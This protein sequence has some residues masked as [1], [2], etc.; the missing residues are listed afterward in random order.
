MHQ[1][2]GP[3]RRR[4]EHRRGPEDRRPARWLGGLARF[5]Q[6]GLARSGGAGLARFRRGGLAT[7]CAAGLLLVLAGAVAAPAATSTLYVDK[8]NPSCSNSGPGNSAVPYCSI[9]KAATAAS[10][11]QTVLVA[12]G[13]YAETVTVGRSGTA[14]APIIFRAQGAVTVRGATYGFRI[15]SK[16]WIT[17]RG[18]TITDTVKEGILVSGSSNITLTGNRVTS[19]GTPASGQTAQGIELSG[20]N[21]ATVSANVTDHNSEAGIQLS[22]SSTRNVVA[23]NESFANARGYTRAAPGIDVRAP[24]NA[25]IGNRAHHNEDTGIQAYTGGSNTLIANNLTWG[26]GDH[27][28][29]DLN[30]PGQRIIGNT[31]YDNVTAGINVEGD[32][33]GATVANNVS[34]DNGIDSPRTKGNIR[35]D[36]TS[37][38]GTTVNDNLVF[39]SASA[40]M[41]TWGSTGYSSLTAFRAA[42]GQ[43]AR[44]IQAD[45][46]FV[47]AGAGDF[48]LGAGSP[49]VDSAN[50]GVSGQQATD[51]DGRPRT[52]DPGVANTGAGP[53]RYDDRGALER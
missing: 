19:A 41:Y 20:T 15:S 4:W 33:P 42:T 43:E 7:A 47:G 46:R 27:G 30:V 8:S 26:N 31:V 36:S 9:A 51:A 40:V 6:S 10:A 34:V 44:G 53:R 23:G 37:V 2:A 38:S 52:D 39:L 21:D 11:G 12:A 18:F 35:V 13:T 48:R 32:S 45:P 5:R 3:S 29:D 14:S 25:V 28:I 17:V 1:L 24:G 16:S 50:S 22:G 49:A